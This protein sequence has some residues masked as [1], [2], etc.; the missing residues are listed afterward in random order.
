MQKTAPERHQNNKAFNFTKKSI[1]D[2]E[3]PSKGRVYYKDTKEKGLSLY[4]TNKGIISFFVRKNINGKDERV[5]IG[6]FP[7]I[8]IEN[9]RKEALK[10]KSD[11]AQGK[12]PNEEKNK[13]RNDITFL[14]MFNEYMNRYS[15]K[16]KKSWKHDEL[17]IKR[18]CNHM[19]KLKA[20]QIRKSDIQN[21][22]NKVAEENGL[23]QA[24]RLLE[25][26]R[27]IYNKTIEWGWE[28][29]NPAK[30]IKK[31]KEKAR[32]RF[33]QP[34]ELP[35]FF[36][37]LENEESQDIKDYVYLSLLTGARKSNILSM[38]WEN[39]SFIR[40]E[41]FIPE[42]KNDEP[43]TIP[44]VEEA[45]KI[46]ENR[47]H[48]QN[49]NIYVFPSNSKFGHLSDPKRGWSRI[50]KRAE[51]NDLRLHD[52]RRSLGSYQAIMG[53]NS[54]I[55]GKSLGHKSQTATAIYARLNIDPVRE[56]MNNAITEMFKFRKK[57]T[58]SD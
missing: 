51:I 28:G 55:I 4:I 56:S 22:H 19:F 42:T 49:K 23:Y 31:F 34:E 41:W 26:I 20:T 12:N 27:A 8:S 7:D 25:K 45:I 44:L 36:E 38:K 5:L 32:S 50:L 35:R 46:L 30:G 52:L 54:Y 21:L 6:R 13:L 15:K 43:I 24:N 40:N 33:L 57:S 11:I 37:A 17:D 18:F 48:H 39:I 1:F 47:K 2:L 16:F 9:A 29:T 14:E 10:I 58:D 53:A 3:K